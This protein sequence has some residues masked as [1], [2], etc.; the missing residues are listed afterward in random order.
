MTSVVSTTVNYRTWHRQVRDTIHGYV[1]LDLVE[2][3]AFP[4]STILNYV[5]LVFPVLLYYFQNSFL[6]LGPDK[7]LF[8]LIGVSAAAG[9]QDALSGLTQRLTFA[10]DRGTLETFLV[11]PVPWA[12]IPVSMN[13][14]RSSIGVISAC[15][16]VG[17][18]GLLGAPLRLTSLPLALLVL[19]LGVIACNAIGTLAASFLIL[20]KRGEPVIMIYGLTASVLGG[21]LFPISALPQWIRWLSYAMPHTYV[22]SAERQLLMSSPPAGLSAGVSIAALAAFCLIGLP[23]ALM[24]FDRSLKLARRLGV[25]SI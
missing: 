15:V 4:A 24:I 18:G 11:E 21:A 23:M 13:L 9:L 8:M 20:F 16:M 2:Q 5:A 3:R 7:F 25:L 6:Q 10:Q 1:R 22:I 19:V 17:L 14:L 12:L